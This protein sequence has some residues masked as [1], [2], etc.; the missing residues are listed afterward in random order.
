VRDSKSSS[1]KIGLVLL[2]KTFLAY[3]FADFSEDFDFEELTSNLKF[4]FLTNFSYS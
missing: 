3:F 1:M 2:F 4:Y